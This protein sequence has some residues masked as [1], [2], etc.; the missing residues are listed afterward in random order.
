MP[1][2]SLRTGSDIPHTKRMTDAINSSDWAETLRLDE[3]IE[4]KVVELARSG[5]HY[6]RASDRQVALSVEDIES[7]SRGYETIKAEGWF[8]TGAPVGY[9]HASMSGAVDAESTKAAG[10]IVEVHTRANDD[11]S[12]SLM[13][14]VR[15]TDEA[16]AR[17]KAGEF[18]GF[19]IEAVPPSAARSKKTGEPLGEWGLI[20]G[21]LTNE[22][23][24]AGM[25][26]VAA[27]EKRNDD[28]S[29][30]KLVSETLVMSEG[31]S[32]EEVLA[33][34]EILRDAAGKV[35]TLTEALDTV[36]ADRDTIQAK[37]DELAAK[38]T[39]RTIDQACADGRIAAS[40]RDDYLDILT[41]CGEELANRAY[42]ADRVGVTEV[43]VAGTETERER[44]ATISS[45]CNALAERLVQEQGLD[46]AAALGRA[47]QIVLSDPTKLAA[48]E[49]ENFDA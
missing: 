22:P 34:I 38:E 19:S 33:S 28:M 36:T 29:F 44:S 17:I 9:N 48:Y 42:F 18:D 31:A 11:G 26:A 49:A 2:S 16:K 43:G 30:I 39:E 8:S 32:E 10:R 37:F 27:S 5:T 25:E 45:E 12:V 23:F 21:T 1:R 41:R 4:D 35:E 3:I 6:G 24:V 14:L 20:G 13:G 7:M 15:W 47:M 40:E 46:E